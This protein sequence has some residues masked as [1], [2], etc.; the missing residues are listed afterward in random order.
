MNISVK[1]THRHMKQ[2]V[3]N[4][5]GGVWGT[6]GLGVWSQQMQT[7]IFRMDKQQDPT[8]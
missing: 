2:T 4:N 3:I 8:V 5:G 1:Q 7:I 6:E